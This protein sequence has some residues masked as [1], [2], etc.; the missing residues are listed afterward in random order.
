MRISSYCGSGNIALPFPIS[1]KLDLSFSTRT[2][3]FK[4][5][6]RN[7]G[8]WKFEKSTVGD[9]IYF[10]DSIK[11]FVT[12]TMAGTMYFGT[13]GFIVRSDF[14]PVFIRLDGVVY[15]NDKLISRSE[16]MMK[17]KLNAIPVSNMQELLYP[18]LSLPA[19]GNIGDKKE[20]LK[21]MSKVYNQT[22]G[23]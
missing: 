10:F 22:Y 18:K 3:I 5:G 6:G 19:F 12:F 9:A 8:E 2:P 1:L 16:V 20:W 11:R 15:C 13:C 23:E 17:N 14:T 21:Q 7:D 4:L